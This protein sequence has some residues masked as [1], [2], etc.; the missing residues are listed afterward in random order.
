MVQNPSILFTQR[1]FK[2]YLEPEYEK[3]MPTDKNLPINFI[4]QC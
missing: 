2:F 4:P 1:P 3:Y